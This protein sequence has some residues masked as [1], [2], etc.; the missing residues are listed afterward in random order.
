MFAGLPVKDLDHVIFFAGDEKIALGFVNRNAL[1]TVQVGVAVRALLIE[2]PRRVNS[3]IGIKPAHVVQVRVN[4]VDTAARINGDA[5]ELIESLFAE[6]R[7]FK[8]I[9]DRGTRFALL[10]Y[11]PRFGRNERVSQV[12]RL[13]RDERHSVRRDRNIND[14]AAEDAMTELA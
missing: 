3:P 13:I 12:E 1:A 4:C 5:A 6:T 10:S 9:L 8:L 2:L 14:L 11:R 7:A